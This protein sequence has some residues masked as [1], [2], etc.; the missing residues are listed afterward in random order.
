MPGSV[1]LFIALRQ[2]WAR[3]TLNG[4]AIG[5][6]TLG[7]L[8]LIAI[9]GIL[10]G[11]H[12]KFLDNILKISPHVTI[13]DK[14][15]RPAP[16][17]LALYT[18]EFVATQIAH[19]VPSNRPLRIGRPKEI[20]HAL[21]DMPGVVAASKLLVGSATIVFGPKEYPLE[22]RGIEPVEQDK[23]TPISAYMNR[24]DF[25]SFQSTSN[26][27]LL[28][29]GVA[30][31]IGA[32]SGD[33]VKVTGASG[34]ALIMKVVGVFDAGIP[35]VDNTRAYV[36]LKDAQTILN[37]IDVVGRI[38]LRLTDPE[39]AIAVANRVEILFG[40]DAESW[41]ETNANFLGIFKQQRMIIDFVVGAVLALG[42]F[43]ILAVQ[44][45]IVLQKT[46]DIAI[47]RSIGFTRRDILA[48]FL[49]QGAVIAAIGAA[50]GDIG[51]HYVIEALGQLKTHTEGLV[52]SETFLVRDDPKLYAYGSAFALGIGLLASVIP[53]WRGSRVE[54]VEVLRGQIG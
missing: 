33:T 53:A 35:P 25:R 30:S 15:L 12:Q 26:G 41:Q 14:E 37:R 32:K 40:Y 50:F 11:F 22:L 18:K 6:V 13:F 31:R 7:V 29:S 1:V 28:G 54:P 36:H 52:R 51:G 27:I 17:M 21:L 8:V 48:A 44:I 45:M 2:L 46:R 39:Q 42:G 34:Q 5:G 16:P 4:I 9:N 19:E 3:R 49:V 23:V 20:V 24:L 43:G 10:T 47:L 38:D